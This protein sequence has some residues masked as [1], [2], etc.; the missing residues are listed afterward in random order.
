MLEELLAAARI[1]SAAIAGF[2]RTEPSH[3]AVA[4][5]VASGS[6]DA[7][8]GIEA[9]AR[10][11]GLDFIALAEEQYFLVTL[12]ASLAHPHVATLLQALGSAE[13]ADVLRQI[14]GYAPERS[15]QV[16]SLRKVLPWW[17]Y[18]KPKR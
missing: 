15:G 4:E 14:P 18:R 11:R 8:F 1:A 16:L 9:A 17:S 5:S 10:A 13:W 3:Q 2:E 12:A 6:A 7:A